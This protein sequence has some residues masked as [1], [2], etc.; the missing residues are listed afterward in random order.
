MELLIVC[1]TSY[2]ERVKRLLYSKVPYTWEQE[3]K[4]KVFTI[5]NNRINDSIFVTRH[6]LDWIKGVGKKIHIIS[7]DLSVNSGRLTRRSYLTREISIR[8]FERR[9]L[10]DTLIALGLDWLSQIELLLRNSWHH[11]EIEREHIEAWIKQFDKYGD[12]AWVAEG[13]LRLL[14]FWSDSRIIDSLK[15]NLEGLKDFDCVAVNRHLRA[16]KSADA[17][18][19][20]VQKRL[21]SARL[22]GIQSNVWDFRAAIEQPEINQILFVEDCLITG[23]EMTRIFMALLGDED[24]FGNKKAEPLTNKDSLYGKKIS[25]RFAVVTN[26]GVAY[27]KRF[28]YLKG[29]TNIEIDLNGT[30]QIKTLTSWGLSCIENDVLYDQD[31]CVIDLDKN[32]IRDSFSKLSIWKTPEKA[33][34]AMHFCAEVGR[35]L[36]E[37]YLDKRN[38]K[39]IEKK[40]NESALGIRSLALALVFS[41]SIPKET[42]PLFWMEAPITRNKKD[43]FWLALFQNGE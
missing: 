40:L 15:I 27:L 21:D 8:S 17:I 38:K 13:L 37:K 31:D 9:T 12:G 19:S 32:I 6:I 29:L 42:L 22:E 36:Y 43:F 3:G 14:E 33:D 26:G 24:P 7:L 35:Q 4:I 20:L 18:A 1:P 25:L 30:L 11:G 5:P 23:N 41:H 28:L 10:P 2:E 34:K 39:M 16:G